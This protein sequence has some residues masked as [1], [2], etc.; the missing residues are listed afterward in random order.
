MGYTTRELESGP[1]SSLYPSC[2]TETQWL[3]WC[4]IDVVITDKT[5][6]QDT[7]PRWPKSIPGNPHVSIVRRHCNG[8]RATVTR[9]GSQDIAIPAKEYTV[10]YEEFSSYPLRM[11][12][13]GVIISTKEMALVAR[14]MVRE[15]GYRYNVEETY[16]DYATLDPRI[17]FEVKDP[18]NR[19]EYLF[20][21]VF[22]QTIQLRCGHRAQMIPDLDNSTLAQYNAECTLSCYLRYPSNYIQDTRETVPVFTINLSDL[23]KGEPYYLPTGDAVCVASSEEGLRDVLAR[24]HVGSAS[25][26]F[27]ALGMVSKDVHEQLV[28]QLTAKVEQ[29]RSIAADQLRAQRAKHDAE[30]A[31]NKSEIDRVKRENEILS[32]QVEYFNTIQ[33]S[34]VDRAEREEKFALQREKARSEQIDASQKS[35]DRTYSMLKIGGAVAAAVLSFAITAYTKKK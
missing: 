16:A 35:L 23:D 4:P 34:M 30:V 31:A 22:G 28:K 6:R 8:P 33:R 26:N 15:S 24:K 3:N 17:V 29:E 20:V 32:K 25:P 7:L 18:F 14:D 13:L 10:N 21:N 9:S 2:Y 5:G 12:E 11:D 1:L 27:A 19:W